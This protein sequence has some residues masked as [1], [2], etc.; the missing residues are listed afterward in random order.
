LLVGPSAVS[1]F[2]SIFC[3]SLSDEVLLVATQYVS[4]LSVRRHPVH[5]RSKAGATGLD[6][7][8]EADTRPSVKLLNGLASYWVIVT[9]SQKCCQSWAASQPAP[10]LGP[11]TRE[12]LTLGIE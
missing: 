11:L 6:A 7:V 5:R 3:A 2:L 9:G 4:D 10:K 1:P 12:R 8:E